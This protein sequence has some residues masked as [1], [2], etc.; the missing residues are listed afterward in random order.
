[1]VEGDQNAPVPN[2]MSPWLRALHQDPSREAQ[3]THAFVSYADETIPM[4]VFGGRFTGAYP[5][6]DHVHV[7]QKLTHRGARDQTVQL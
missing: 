6:A 2:D 4:Q 5:T 1:M 3:K 7:F